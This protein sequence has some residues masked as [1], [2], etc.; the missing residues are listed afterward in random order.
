MVEEV[1]ARPVAVPTCVRTGSPGGT[2]GSTAGRMPTTTGGQGAD[3][4]GMEN[5]AHEKLAVDVLSWQIR[6]SRLILAVG[7]G[8]VGLSAIWRLE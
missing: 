3:A 8:P 2:P 5:R 4:Q 6:V 7:A 1:P